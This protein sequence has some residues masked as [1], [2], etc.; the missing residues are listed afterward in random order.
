MEEG[1]GWGASSQGRT[2]E[3][4]ADP[5]EQ[6]AAGPAPHIPPE[7]PAGTYPAPPTSPR[8]HTYPGPGI[9][10]ADFSTGCPTSSKCLPARLALPPLGCVGFRFCQAGGCPVEPP[11]GFRS[12]FPIPEVLAA[13]PCR[14]QPRRSR[15]CAS[16]ASPAVRLHRL[17]DS[18]A[19]DLVSSSQCTGA[20]PSPCPGAFPTPES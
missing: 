17:L 12:H 4:H 1:L 14:A 18:Q 20:E 15:A 6:R 19:R 7:D 11:S 13:E 2:G 10:I 16:P 5:S 8:L 3:L 9:P